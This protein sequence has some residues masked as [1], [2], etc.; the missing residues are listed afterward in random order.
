MCVQVRHPVTDECELGDFYSVYWRKRFSI[1]D[2]TTAGER[3]LFADDQMINGQMVKHRDW[4]CRPDSADW[5]IIV[6]GTGLP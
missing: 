1:I 3:C 6:V 4:L 5:L 2:A